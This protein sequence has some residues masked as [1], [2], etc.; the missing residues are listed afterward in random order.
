MR[1]GAELVLDIVPRFLQSA[2][3]RK[4]KGYGS[5]REENGWFRWGPPHH[6]RIKFRRCLVLFQ[7]L[8]GNCTSERH[9]L[10]VQYIGMVL[11]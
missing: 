4:I 3:A 7:F 6:V 5:R 1:N 11:E 2:F 10:W 8:A 9:P